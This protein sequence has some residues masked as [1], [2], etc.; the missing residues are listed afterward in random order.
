MRV[1]VVGEKNETRQVK[2]YSKKTSLSYFY[3]VFFALFLRN[4]ERWR[5][6]SVC[7]SVVLALLFLVFVVV[8]FRWLLLWQSRE[9]AEDN[10]ERMTKALDTMLLEL[11]VPRQIV[12][13]ILRKLLQVRLFVFLFIVHSFC[14]SIA[15]FFTT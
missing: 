5:S 1:N 14:S 15:F 7:C 11:Q 2:G 10:R 3:S 9:M 13:P 6:A 12:N 4:S 8:V